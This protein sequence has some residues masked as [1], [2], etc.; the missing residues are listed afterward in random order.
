LD[1]L[2][3]AVTNRRTVPSLCNYDYGES[4]GMIGRGN[5]CT[6]RKP[7]PTPLCPPQIPHAARTRTRAAAVGSQRLTTSATA[8]PIFS[9]APCSRT[10]SIHVPPSGLKTKTP[11]FYFRNHLHK[12]M[13]W[14]ELFAYFHLIRHE[15]HRTRRI[16]LLIT[17][18]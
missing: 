12:N 7:T 13:I 16:Q 18:C 9:L 10:R 14:V 8:R 5:R 11:H 2:G 17:N 1:P 15:T 4:D 6:R 3:T